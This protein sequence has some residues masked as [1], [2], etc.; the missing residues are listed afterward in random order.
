VLLAITA[1]GNIREVDPRRPQ[2]V[3]RDAAAL[4]GKSLADL[5]APEER[6]LLARALARAATTPA[7]WQEVTFVAA[8]GR[9]EPMLCCFQRLAPTDLPHAAILVT[10]LKLERLESVLRN[11]A[12]AA[13]GHLAFRC[14]GP[15]HRLMQAIEAILSQYPWNEAAVRSREELDGVLEALSLSADW[16]HDLPTGGPVNVVDVLEGALRLVDGD[17]DFAGLAV[18]L[19]PDCP[20][21]WA[22]VHPVGLA[23][24][25]LHLVAN[26]RDATLAAKEPRLFI[27]VNLQGDRVVL[28]FQDNGRGLDREDLKCVFAPFFRRDRRPDGRAGVGLATCSELLHFMGG[29]IHMQSQPE[30]GTTVFVSLPAA[31]APE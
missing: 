15:A 8:D 9:P 12:A 27:D 22:P 28:E 4:A 29:T 24:V 23:F 7:V 19:R 11:E 30:R 17:P 25:T 26:A 18:S 31:R 21:A 10:G 5:V 14:H 3:G 13:L 6:Q 2:V 1:A 16:P 20:S